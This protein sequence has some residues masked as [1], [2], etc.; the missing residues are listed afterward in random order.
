MMD[1]DFSQ[2]IRIRTHKYSKEGTKIE[3]L[4]ILMKI[5]FYE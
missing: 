5:T 2:T 1:P 3:Y 4:K